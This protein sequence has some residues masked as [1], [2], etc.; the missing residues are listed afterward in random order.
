MLPSFFDVD[1]DQVAGCGVL[2]PADGTAGGAV[3]VGQAGQAVAG[4]HPVH[5]GRIDA[6]QVADGGRSPPARHPHLD[7]AS[8]KARGGAAWTAV[9]A[10]GAVGHG[11]LAQLAVPAGPAVRALPRHPELGGDVRDRPPVEHDPANQQTSA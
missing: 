7:D 2:V 1:V 4:Q 8:F 11:R 6:Q 10:A 9:R 3:Q 5:R